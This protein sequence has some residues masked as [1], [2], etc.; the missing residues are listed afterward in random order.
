VEKHDVNNDINYF[1][2][3]PWS[4]GQHYR[5]GSNL[6]QALEQRARGKTSQ[7][8]RC[9][10]DLQQKTVR[11]VSDS[12]EIDIPIADVVIGELGKG[13]IF[14]LEHNSAIRMWQNNQYATKV[15]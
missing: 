6:G 8:I 13:L 11:T 9:L 3:G 14:E 10:L 15:N 1:V 5:D 7:A 12:E 2:A 4:H